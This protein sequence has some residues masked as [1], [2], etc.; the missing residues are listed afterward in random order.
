MID[1]T[2]LVAVYNA[3]KYLRE[4]LDS[5]L[6]QS[7]QAFQVICVDDG[8]T[9]ASWDILEDYAHRDSRIETIQLTENHGQAHARNVGLRHAKGTYTCFLDSDDCLS[10]DALQSAV[11]VFHAHRQ[12]DCVL[13]HVVNCDEQG[14]KI[15]DYPMPSFESLSGDDAFEMSLT[16]K[17]HGIYMVR[18]DIHLQYPYDESCKSYSDDNTTRIHYLKSR[19]VRCC[20]GIY[21]YRQHAASVT[22][23][24]NAS[25]FDYLRANESMKRQLIDLHVSDRILSLYE[26][27]RWL[28]LIDTYMFYYNHRKQL[29]STEKAYGLSEIKRVWKGIDISRL[30][31]RHCMKF[32]YMPFRCSWLLFRLQE[33]AYFFLRRICHK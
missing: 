31:L 25:R 13:F 8:S 30:S 24:I 23:R 3:E 10:P 29:S 6:S 16:W 2:I 14:T 33:E 15:S 21:E 1:V 9:D 28:V 11:D 17:I 27:V 5:L 7:L 12:T 32:G 4:C 19:E 18:T 20:E 22:H 26:N